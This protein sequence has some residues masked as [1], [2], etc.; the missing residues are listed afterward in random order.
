MAAS[1]LF[2]SRLSSRALPAAWSSPGSACA[3]FGSTRPA[4]GL[5][6]AVPRRVVRSLRAGTPA[7]AVAPE[8]ALPTLP[9][10]LVGVLVLLAVL[11]APERPLDQAAI[12]QR[13]AG[14]VACRV[15]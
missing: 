8:S 14:P 12:C 4:S 11:V 1:L 9:L 15:W 10:V 5:S 2:T 3:S 13:H 6:Q 7:G